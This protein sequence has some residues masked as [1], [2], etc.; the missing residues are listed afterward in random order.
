MEEAKDSIR[1]QGRREAFERQ[2]DEDPTEYAK[3]LSGYADEAL[4]TFRQVAGET[5]QPGDLMHCLL[6]WCD[7]NGFT[8]GGSINGAKLS[9]SF[10]RGRGMAE[11]DE[12][13]WHTEPDV[14]INENSPDVPSDPRHLD[15]AADSSG[16]L[17]MS[18]TDPGTMMFART[19]ADQRDAQR[20]ADFL[21]V[22]IR[23]QHARSRPN[24]TDEE[25]NR[26]I[27]VAR[28]RART[29]SRERDER[30]LQLRREI[31]TLACWAEGVIADCYGSAAAY[32]F[33]D[34]FPDIGNK[35]ELL[36]AVRWELNEIEGNEDVERDDKECNQNSKTAT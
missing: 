13:T 16:V 26:Q 17:I 15:V 19:T 35:L 7:H 31:Q 3:R 11:W 27:T 34:K 23:E 32:G 25:W 14:R 10:D 9:Y 21:Q 36:N 18:V 29:P 1:R 28:D 30:K 22:W 33:E 2:N 4:E 6:H 12:R 5:L 20:L 8:A 24:V